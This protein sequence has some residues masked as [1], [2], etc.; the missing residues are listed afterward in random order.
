M[1]KR[2]L[3]LF[4]LTSYFQL[5]LGLFSKIENSTDGRIINVASGAH[6]RYRL[7]IKDL[8]N[9]INYSYS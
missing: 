5:S 6:K 9:K 4:F 8:E 2:T 7:D 3:I 1:I